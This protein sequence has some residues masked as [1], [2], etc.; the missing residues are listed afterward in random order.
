MKSYV[1]EE[2]LVIVVESKLDIQAKLKVFE[3]RKYACL[4]V[5]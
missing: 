1:G 5:I 4:G 2:S 3:N